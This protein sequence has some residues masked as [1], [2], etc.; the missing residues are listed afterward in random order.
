MEIKTQ[1]EIFVENTEVWSAVIT[2][3]I[4]QLTMSS[5]TH[6]QLHLA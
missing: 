6:V 3:M 4:K 1:S 2:P 5:P